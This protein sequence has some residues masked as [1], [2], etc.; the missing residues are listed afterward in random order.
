MF[1]LHPIVLAALTGFLSGLLL[2]IPVGP[3]NL[4]I[5]NEGARRG[6]LWAFMIGMGATAMEVIYCFVAFTG[7]ASFFSR[8][9]IKAAMELF[10]FVF[11]LFLGVKFLMAQNVSHVPVNLG[12]RADRIEEQL[13]ERLK[14]HSAFM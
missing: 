8:G 5:M 2:S 9:I 1:H 10:S 4:T 11:M 7:F 6:F 3:V 12:A 13:E 14:P